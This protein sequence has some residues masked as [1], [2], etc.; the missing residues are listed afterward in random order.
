MFTKFNN[1]VNGREKIYDKYLDLEETLIEL[2][3]NPKDVKVN[4][5]YMRNSKN[6]TWKGIPLKYIID[7]I[8]TEFVGE[9]FPNKGYIDTR[10]QIYSGEDDEKHYVGVVK[11]RYDGKVL[12]TFIKCFPDRG[13]SIDF[14]VSK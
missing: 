14:V 9:I 10:Y 5:S 11:G 7:F 1:W 4:F 3:K 6:T 8:K 12:D 13:A 2:N